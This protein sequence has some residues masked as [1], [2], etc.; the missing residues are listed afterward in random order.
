MQVKQVALLAAVLCWEV[1]RAVSLLAPGD[2]KSV[3]LAA[4][5][6]ADLWEKVSGETPAIIDALPEKGDVVVFGER[7]KGQSLLIQ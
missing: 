2:S 5:T 6:F 7:M 1:A 3:R 4:E